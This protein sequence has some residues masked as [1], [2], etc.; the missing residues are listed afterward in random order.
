MEKFAP[1]MGNM[2]VEN[3][4][5]K[6][7]AMEFIIVP[8]VIFV[9]LDMITIV[10]GQENALEGEIYAAFIFSYSGH[11]FHLSWDLL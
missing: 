9:L 6:Q 11:S 8:P 5:S 3:A 10:F 1:N 4:M 7:D 2:Y